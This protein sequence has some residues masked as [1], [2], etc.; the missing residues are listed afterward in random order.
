MEKSEQNFRPIWSFIF[1]NNVLLEMQLAN[2][3]KRATR[4]AFIPI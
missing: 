1:R 2:E 3:S 4:P